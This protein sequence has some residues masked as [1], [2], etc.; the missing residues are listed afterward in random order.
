[1]AFEGWFVT[2]ATRDIEDG[3]AG[4]GFP[5]G[6]QRLQKVEIVRTDGSTVPLQRNERHA[7]GNS[8]ESASTGDSYLPTFRMFGN[9][10]LLEPTPS[11]NITNGLQLEYAGLPVYIDGESDRLHPS[12]PELFDELVVL[13]TAV[14]CLDAEGIH[15][16]GAAST[17]LRLRME[18]EFDWERFIDQR[19]VSRDAIERFITSYRDA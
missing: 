5:D 6:V 8:A 11:A 7:A 13:D 10:I 17:I 12:F 14:M 16:T 2:V 1:M 18:L 3:K 19:S 9:G 15:E 4:Y